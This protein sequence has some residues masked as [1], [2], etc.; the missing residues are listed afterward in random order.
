MGDTVNLA[1]RLMSAAPAGEVYATSGVL[2][3]LAPDLRDESPR[4][5]LGEGQGAA[6]AGLRDGRRDRPPRHGPP[7]GPV[8]RAVTMS[9]ERSPRCCSAPRPT[10]RAVLTVVGDTGMGK[11]RLVAEA[12]VATGARIVHRAR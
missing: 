2:D 1:A 10:V 4:A 8:R 7:G 12:L 6:G 3:R 5:L 9:C 11:S